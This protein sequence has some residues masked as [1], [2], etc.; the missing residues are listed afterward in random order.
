VL[1]DAVVEH[2]LEEDV[3]AV[4]WR[5]TITKLPDVHPRAQADV[6]APVEGLDGVFGVVVICHGEIDD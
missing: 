4:F 5:R 2:L 1:V 6:L 3:D